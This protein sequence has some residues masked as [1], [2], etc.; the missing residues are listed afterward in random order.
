M[1]VLHN[2]NASVFQTED[3]GSIPFTRFGV[4][5]KETTIVSEAALVYFDYVITELKKTVM[6]FAEESAS[7]RYASACNHTPTWSSP[8]LIL[9][10]DIEQAF[11]ELQ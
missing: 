6:Q 5:M 1:R 7:K 10:E 8:T 3:E 11:E 4:N 2:G 9:V